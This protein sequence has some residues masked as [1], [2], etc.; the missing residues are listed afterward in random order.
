MRSQTLNVIYFIRA[1]EPKTSINL[2]CFDDFCLG[3]LTRFFL[4]TSPAFNSA[5]IGYRYTWSD[6]SYVSYQDN[7]NE[8]TPVSSAGAQPAAPPR[9][10]A[11][12]QSKKQSAPGPQEFV[13]QNPLQARYAM[14]KLEL[15][16]LVHHKRE[17]NAAGK[18][19]WNKP[20]II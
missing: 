11:S 3:T 6:S 19:Y 8:P 13:A 20:Q 7:K 4:S 12:S 18:F 1:L 14:C 15:K 9:P 17:Q 16:N 2:K 10:D 5:L